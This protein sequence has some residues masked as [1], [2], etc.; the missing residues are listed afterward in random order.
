L[1]LYRLFGD[2]NGDG[3]VDQTDLGQ[4]R[5]A[6]NAGIGNPLYLSYLDA[7]NGGAVDQLALGQF[8]SRFNSSV[9]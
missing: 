3:I 5:S 4:F 9:F 2:A 1:H 7:D 8:R 6:F